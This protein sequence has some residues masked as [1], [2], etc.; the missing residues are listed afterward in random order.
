MSYR[1]TIVSDHDEVLDIIN[2]DGY[3]LTKPLAQQALGDAVAS[4]MGSRHVAECARREHAE[5]D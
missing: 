4:G 1:V 2:I 5:E 3:D